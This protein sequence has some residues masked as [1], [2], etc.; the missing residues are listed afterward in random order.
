MMAGP[1]FLLESLG[2]AFFL[3]EANNFVHWGS[4]IEDDIMVLFLM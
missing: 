4:N 3:L 1:I 2:G